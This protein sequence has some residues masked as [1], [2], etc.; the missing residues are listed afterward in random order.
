M[1]AHSNL[2]LTSNELLGGDGVF[3]VS[4]RPWYG[5]GHPLKVDD[6]LLQKESLLY[7]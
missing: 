2:R 1:F 7:V 4:F 6:V 3:R 5:P